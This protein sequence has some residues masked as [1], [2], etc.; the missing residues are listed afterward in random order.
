[1]K[2]VSSRVY[3][4]PCDL[5]DAVESWLRKQG[6]ITKRHVVAVVL[7]QAHGVYEARLSPNLGRIQPPGKGSKSDMGHAMQKALKL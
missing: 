5:R 1:M 6:T 2:Q 4:T 3:L 7:R